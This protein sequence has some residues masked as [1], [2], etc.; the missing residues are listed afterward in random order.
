MSSMQM[1]FYRQIHNLHITELKKQLL[2]KK[3]H[4]RIALLTVAIIE[5]E[6]IQREVCTK[7]F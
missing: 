2:Y 4:L 6:I 5:D 1:D 7:R 3:E